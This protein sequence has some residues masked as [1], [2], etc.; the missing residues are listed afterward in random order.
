[1]P[2]TFDTL[3]YAL[4]ADDGSAAPAYPEAGPALASA[5][6]GYLVTAHQSRA[7]RPHSL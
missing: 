7:N 3:L 5:W 2:E 6:H 1:M 4:E